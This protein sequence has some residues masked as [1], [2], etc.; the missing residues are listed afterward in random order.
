MYRFT[1]EIFEVNDY[2]FDVI[3][4]DGSTVPYAYAW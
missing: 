4:D 1:Q 3:G 2:D